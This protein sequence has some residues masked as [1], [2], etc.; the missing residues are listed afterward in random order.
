MSGRLLLRQVLQPRQ[1][2][3]LRPQPL[4]RQ[5][6]VTDAAH[7]LVS[8]IAEHVDTSALIIWMMMI[9]V[10]VHAGHGVVNIVC[11]NV[12]VIH[13]KRL[14][15]PSKQ[16][17]QQRP[18]QLQPRHQQAQLR[19]KQHHHLTGPTL[20]LYSL[21]SG[22]ILITIAKFVVGIARTTMVHLQ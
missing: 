2:L 1:Q 22:P 14:D 7:H 3:L 21:P 10:H 5:L 15:Q 13:G 18:I 6:Y 17:H 4:L 16:L 11:L 12:L 8:T 20:Q 9:I 19:L